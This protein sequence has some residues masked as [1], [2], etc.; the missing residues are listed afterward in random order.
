[1]SVPS[2]PTT[3]HYASFPPSSDQ[4]SPNSVIPSVPPYDVIQKNDRNST[5][6]PFQLEQHRPA[7][8]PKR[9]EAAWACRVSSSASHRTGATINERLQPIIERIQMGYQRVD[10]KNLISLAV[11]NVLGPS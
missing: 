8:M 3:K 6:D 7:K 10:R 11:S 2:V 5:S 1:M 4:R 9:D